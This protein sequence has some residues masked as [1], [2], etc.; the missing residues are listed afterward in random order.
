[1]EIRTDN[2]TEVIFWKPHTPPKCDFCILQ[3][4][5]ATVP[6]VARTV[7]IYVEFFHDVACHKLSKLVS[8]SWNYCKNKSG[9]YYLRHGIV[10]CKCVI[11]LASKGFWSKMLGV[12]DFYYELGIQIIEVCLATSHHN[13]GWFC[14]VFKETFSC[15]KLHISIWLLS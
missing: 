4:N 10:Q 9:T 15:F 1:M 7:V 11:F 6:M 2:Q 8:V 3:G 12:G 13:G 5:V 14:C